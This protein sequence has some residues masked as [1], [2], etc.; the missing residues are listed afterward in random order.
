MKKGINRLI[1]SKTKNLQGWV[2]QKH[3]IFLAIA[4]ISFY[5]QTLLKSFYVKG[6]DEVSLQKQWAQQVL[7]PWFLNTIPYKEI[8]VL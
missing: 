7:R 8:M 5:V 4:Q 1:N 3:L 6:L 2:S